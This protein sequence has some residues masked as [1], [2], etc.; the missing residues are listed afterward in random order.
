MR[1]LVTNDDGVEAPGVLALAEA[2]VA[3]GH[4]VVAVDL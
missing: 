1:V 4:E 3:A 2:I